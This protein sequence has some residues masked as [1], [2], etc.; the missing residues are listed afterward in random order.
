MIGNPYFGVNNAMSVDTT[1]QGMYGQNA[2]VLPGSYGGDPYSVVGN[3]GN[4]Y[5]GGAEGYLGPSA[6]MTPALQQQYNF[7]RSSEGMAPLPGA[8][9]LSIADFRRSMLSVMPQQPQNPYQG[10]TPFGN[11]YTRYLMGG[12]QRQNRLARPVRGDFAFG[13]GNPGKFGQPQFSG[14]RPAL[15]AVQTPYD[16]VG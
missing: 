10:M 5:S 13:G 15:P 12:G 1:K 11:H 2:M 8:G 9:P 7:A 4:S 16:T 6:P 14:Y 3:S